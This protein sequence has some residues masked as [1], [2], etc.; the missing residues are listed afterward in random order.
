[1]ASR[2]GHNK[3]VHQLLDV[4]TDVNAILERDYNTAL[5]AVVA[6]GHKDII[7]Q[8]LDAGADIN[9]YLKGTL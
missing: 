3:I 1:M 9:R 5:Q 6:K 4:G 7:Q 8:L 2:E